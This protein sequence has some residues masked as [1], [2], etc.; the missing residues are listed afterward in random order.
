MT[1]ESVA[2]PLGFDAAN[3][4]HTLE[5]LPH[6]VW[7]AGPDGAIEYVNRRCLDYSGLQMSGLTGW[8]WKSIVHPDDLARSVATWTKSIRTGESHV[9]EYRLRRHDGVYRWFVARGQP[10][11]DAAGRVIRWF[12]TCTDVD[13]RKKA[14][15][16]LRQ[17][18][19]L[20]R[21][22][23]ERSYEG[24][25][26]MGANRM[27]IYASPA[28]NRLLG[29]TPEEFVGMDLWEWAHPDSR[30]GLSAWLT[31]LL[32]R[33]GE[34]IEVCY[35]FRHRDGSYRRLELRATN[36]LDEPDVGAVVVNFWDLGGR[37][38]A[39]PPEPMAHDPTI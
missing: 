9:I 29:Y 3:Y 13:D 16:A 14:E 31:H 27:V 10:T 5:A 8:E 33:A 12:G 18:E 6:L 17:T 23:V 37:L 32:S 24:F 28:V 7:V 36:L 2:A 19:A 20:F 4:Q 1:D 34:R 39:T 21:A 15:A 11:H 26:L 22:I 30:P 25:A 35:R 38:P